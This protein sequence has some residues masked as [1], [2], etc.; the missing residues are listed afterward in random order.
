MLRGALRIWRGIAFKDTYNM[1]LTGG[2]LMPTALHGLVVTNIDDAI[3]IVGGGQQPG[4]S[5]SNANEISHI[6]KV[7]LTCS[8]A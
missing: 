1:I 2:V 7:A 5:V 8:E 4:S 6:R 3:Y